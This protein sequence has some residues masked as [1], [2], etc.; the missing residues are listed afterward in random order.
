MYKGVYC[1]TVHI[2]KNRDSPNVYHKATEKIYNSALLKKKK[3]DKSTCTHM[4][5]VVQISE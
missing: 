3:L 1:S 2:R 5:H 4:A